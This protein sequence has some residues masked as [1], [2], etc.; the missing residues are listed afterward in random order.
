[1]EIQDLE[2]FIDESSIIS[3]ADANGKIT[4]VNKKF[5]DISGYSLEEVIGKDH[6]I[7]NSGEHPKEFWAE[8]YK[9]TVREK[10]VWNSVVTNRSKS[11]D[12][13]YVDTFIKAQF[14]PITGKLRGFMSIRQDVTEIIKNT[15]EIEKKNVYL[16]HA[17]KIL[18]HDMH[19]G[20]NTYIPRGLSSLDRRITSEHAKELN[21]DAPI[22][23][24]R[25]GLK[26][27]QKVYKG[28][29]EFTNLVKKDS[30]LNKQSYNLDEILID[31][32]SSTAYKHQV[33]IDD[34]G[35]CDVN[36]ALFC[37]A[38]DNLIRN[39]LKYNDS[40]T[41]II[42]ISRLKDTILVED[43]GRGMNEEEFKLLSKPYTRKTDQK[44]TGTGL[45][46][47]ICIAIL[48]E[49]GFYITCSKLPQG[50]TQIKIK[51]NN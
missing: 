3:K 41:K 23:M 37:T 34:L 14:N 25:E 4:Y 22:K 47:N 28:V 39:G 49:H 44:E 42:N 19:S 24:I 18:R 51:L 17:A 15:I 48:E 36:E 38:L 12:F 13:Y 5:T 6:S 11:G 20:I 9:T 26:H 43:N 50:G 32:L 29:Y 35:S 2:E 16:E 30:E 40:D 27:A 10:R 21:I 31:Y 33:N 7:V 1:M 8:M 45:G 46:L